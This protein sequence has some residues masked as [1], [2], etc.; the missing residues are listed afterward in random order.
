[1]HST[2]A[3][4]K[5]EGFIEAK[6]QT[7]RDSHTL[8]QHCEAVRTTGVI[9]WFMSMTNLLPAAIDRS[10][11]PICTASQP[12]RM[13]QRQAMHISSCTQKIYLTGLHADW[14]LRLLNVVWCSDF[15]AAVQHRTATD[16]A[17][18]HLV[19]CIELTL[20]NHCTQVL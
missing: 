19:Q 14:W 9:A 3:A 16:A 10:D 18:I 12:C 15:C 17:R 1:M 4:H 2:S 7:D 6:R 13:A 20:Y 8:H 11:G 5:L